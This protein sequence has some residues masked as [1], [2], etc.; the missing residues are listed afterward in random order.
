MLSVT[1]HQFSCI[2]THP[3]V[4]QHQK[5]GASKLQ[6]Q[7]NTLRHLG[8]HQHSD[9]RVNNNNN[10]AMPTTLKHTAPASAY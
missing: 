6:L 9:Y 4:P 2:V 3:M 7:L 1:Q 10:T 8:A 5:L